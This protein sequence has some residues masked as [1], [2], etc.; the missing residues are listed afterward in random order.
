MQ[1]WK[2]KGRPSG[3]F[4]STALTVAILTES[5]RSVESL[6]NHHSKNAAMAIRIAKAAIHEADAFSLLGLIGLIAGELG[7]R[8]KQSLKEKLKGLIHV[9]S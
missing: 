9:R 3:T 2:S 6:P 1:K 8:G 7:Q 4:D 5:E